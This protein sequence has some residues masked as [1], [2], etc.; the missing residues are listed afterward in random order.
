MKCTVCSKLLNSNER[1]EVRQHMEEYKDRP[2][3][4]GP[5]KCNSCLG[6]SICDSMDR[7]KDLVNEKIENSKKKRTV[8]QLECDSCK[9]VF[10]AAHWEGVKVPSD[11]RCSDCLHEEIFELADHYATKTHREA[12][13][14]VSRAVE[15]TKK[16]YE[17]GLHGPRTLN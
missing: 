8:I 12:L 13:G 4:V 16:E 5:I 6:K 2:F 10:K 3:L 11:L 7:I 14:D 15:E 1:D 17:K 9:K